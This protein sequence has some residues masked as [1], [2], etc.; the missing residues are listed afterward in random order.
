MSWF[1]KILNVVWL[2]VHWSINN[3]N[4]KDIYKRDLVSQ[5]MLF[6]NVLRSMR[7]SWSMSWLPD[8]LLSATWAVSFHKTL[9]TS[10]LSGGQDMDMWFMSGQKSLRKVCQETLGKIPLLTPMK[11]NGR[12][13]SPSHIWGGERTWGLQFLQPLLTRGKSQKK[14]KQK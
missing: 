7:G 3:R 1:I 12:A 8:L 2:V 14:L 5:K 6:F 4:S 11:T 13:P 10:Q 9:S